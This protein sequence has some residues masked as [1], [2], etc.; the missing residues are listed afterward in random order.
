MTNQYASFFERIWYEY[1]E[2]WM[3]DFYSRIVEATKI[4]QRQDFFLL[5]GR[6]NCVPKRVQCPKQNRHYLAIPLARLVE[7]GIIGKTGKLPS[8]YIIK[9]VYL[10]GLKEETVPYIKLTYVQ[11]LLKRK[12]ALVK[13]A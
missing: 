8:K 7:A 12:K 11:Q 10:R 13:S 9:K 2:Q 5:L 6:L 3:K 4:K 1:H